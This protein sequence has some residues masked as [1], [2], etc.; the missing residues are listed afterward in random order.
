MPFVALVTLGISLFALGFAVLT[1][2]IQIRVG[3][4]IK[5]NQEE[6]DRYQRWLDRPP[7]QRAASIDGEKE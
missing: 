2:V 1:G 7:L 4:R 5:R 3:R 6:F